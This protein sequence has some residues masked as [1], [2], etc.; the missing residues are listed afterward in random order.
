LKELEK[1][2]EIVKKQEDLDP[3]CVKKKSSMSIF[4]GVWPS[5][6]LGVLCDRALT[7]SVVDSLAFEYGSDV[8]AKW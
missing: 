8:G 1:K 3:G 2:K 4:D 5:S 7:E 6:C